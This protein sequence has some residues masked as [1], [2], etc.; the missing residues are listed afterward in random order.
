MARYHPDYEGSIGDF[1]EPW[2]H[3]HPEP[4][5]D[6]YH[7]GSVGLFNTLQDDYYPEGPATLRPALDRDGEWPGG[8]EDYSYSDQAIEAL[9]GQCRRLEG[10][11]KLEQN[12][13]LIGKWWTDEGEDYHE[14]G[15]WDGDYP[16][17]DGRFFHRGAGDVY[18]PIGFGDNQG[19]R[20]HYEG[21]SV[22]Y[23]GRL[24][25]RYPF[26]EDPPPE[27]Y[28]DRRYRELRPALS[29]DREWPAGPPRYDHMRQASEAREMEDERRQRGDTSMVGLP[30]VRRGDSSSRQRPPLPTWEDYWG[31]NS[32]Y[33][34]RRAAQWGGGLVPKRGAQQVVDGDETGFCFGRLK[35]IDVSQMDE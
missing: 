10:T 22:G 21:E 23:R 11:V 34:R 2:D 16:Y 35:A 32:E 8:P 4:W 33:E 30:P 6:P 25:S 26:S 15:P 24:D 14:S 1:N 27:G 9:Q 17:E 7:E 3:L 29:S 28:V 19:A 18:D 13:E 5:Y 20:D 31:P 12:A